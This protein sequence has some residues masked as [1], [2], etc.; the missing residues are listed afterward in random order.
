MSTRQIYVSAEGSRSHSERQRK[1]VPE[2]LSAVAPHCHHIP[3]FDGEL[4]SR[5]WGNEAE[6]A[7]PRWPDYIGR[8]WE[9]Q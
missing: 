9:V 8:A 4:V 3:W 6:G 7:S 5:F 1:F 2:P